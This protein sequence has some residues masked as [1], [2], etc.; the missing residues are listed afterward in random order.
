MKIKKI[1]VPVDFSEFSITALKYAAGF[2]K[3]SGAGIFI[4]HITDPDSLESELRGNLGHEHLMDVTRKSDFLTGIKTTALFKKGKVASLILEESH[5]NDIDL[6]VMG[7]RGAG[8][9]A[10]NLFGTNTTHVVGKSECPVLVIPDEAVYQP[11]RKVIMAVDLEQNSDQI[12]EEFINLIKN[13]NA[14]ILITYVGIDKDGRFERNLEKLTADLKKR[15]NYEKVVGKIIH[16]SEFPM[17][18]GDFA[19]NIEADM[20]VMIT[21]HRGIF[22]SIFDPSETKLLAYHITIPLMV[23]PQHRIPVFFF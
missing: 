11:V 19:L 2:A 1:L 6:V 16:S 17:S 10:R 4:L 7:T 5:R 20:L 15:T 22:E 13:L 8:N 18:L 23:I 14:A 9:A 12:L 3:K 21:H